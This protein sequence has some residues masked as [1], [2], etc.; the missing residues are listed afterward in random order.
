MSADPLRQRGNHA[1]L[2]PEIEQLRRAI[3]TDDVERVKTILTQNPS[4]HGAPLGYGQSGPLTCAAECNVPP[5]AERLAIC[6]LLDH[7]ASPN[8]DRPHR[9]HRGTALDY[10]IGSYVR[11]PD[12]SPCID[13]LLHAGARTKYDVPVVLELL[14]G[15]LDRVKDHLRADPSLV[16]A[17][18]RDLD[19]GATGGRLLTLTGATLLHVAVEYR[20]LE[21]VHLLLRGGADVNGRASIDEDGVGGQ[22]AIFHAVT[23]AGDGGLSIARLL[24]DRGADLSI[25]VKVPGQYERAG[26]VVECTPLGYALRFQDE[27]ARGDKVKMVALLRERGGGQ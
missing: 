19:C 21:G 3:E 14:R 11:S 20:N 26:E 15:N 12:L 24:I 25:R 17:R 6:G 8:C 5:S 10:V 13:A 23:Q 7:G 9:A 22:T 1:A 2:G 18:F 16:S 27:P 4:L